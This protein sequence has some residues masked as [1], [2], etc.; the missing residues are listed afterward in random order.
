[1]SSRFAIFGPHPTCMHHHVALQ[2]SVLSKP[3]CAKWTSK[4][5]GS[6]MDEHVGFKISRSWERLLTKNAFVRLV[7]KI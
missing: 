3:S 7:L 1:M 5:P 2:Q 6:S 4:W